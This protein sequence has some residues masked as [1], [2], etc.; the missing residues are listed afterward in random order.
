ML[1]FISRFLVF[2]L[3]FFLFCTVE[4]LSIHSY[5]AFI[6]GTVKHGDYVALIASLVAVSFGVVEFGCS[7]PIA[8][9]GFSGMLNDA[10]HVLLPVC[11]IGPEQD[12]LHEHERNR[13]PAKGRSHTR[14]V[15][16]NKP[17]ATM[18]KLAPIHRRPRLART[19]QLRP[20]ALL[21]NAPCAP[22]SPA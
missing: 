14:L 15:A 2:F 20:R 17:A 13:Q 9:I 12:C 6:W 18:P 10:R 11:R 1:P 4:T 22:C 7:C 16:R 3:L 21:S 19:S 5:K 8:F